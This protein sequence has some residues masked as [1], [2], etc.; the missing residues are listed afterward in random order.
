MPTPTTARVLNVGTTTLT[1][2]GLS[3]VSPSIILFPFAST[4]ADR[5]TTDFV[6]AGYYYEVSRR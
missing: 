3:V 5:S 1:L 4:S 2:I 6:A